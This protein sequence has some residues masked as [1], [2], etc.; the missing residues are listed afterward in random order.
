[1]TLSKL[2]VSSASNNRRDE[3]TST[4]KNTTCLYFEDRTTLVAGGER[5]DDTSESRRSERAVRWQRAPR[6]LP[7][8]HSSTLHPDVD[9]GTIVITNRE[10][11]SAF[12]CALPAVLAL[13]SSSSFVWLASS[14]ASFAA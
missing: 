11:I 13:S 9:C 5:G 10:R 7:P 12:P 8:P 6:R 14:L 2:D 3:L 1:V 4:K